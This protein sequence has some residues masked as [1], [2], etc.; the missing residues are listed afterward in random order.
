MSNFVIFQDFGFD[1]IQNIA[2]AFDKLYHMIIDPIVEAVDAIKELVEIVKDMTFVQLVNE[3][4]QIF[5]SLPNTIYKIV[6]SVEKAYTILID[7]DGYPLIDRFKKVINRVTTFIN[8]VKSDVL[9]FYH[10]S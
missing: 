5:K 3:L 2:S 1:K 4:I 9:E 6:E 8:D 10:V 7:Y